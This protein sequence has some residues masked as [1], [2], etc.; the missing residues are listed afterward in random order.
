[1]IIREIPEQECRE[2][3]AR[4]SIGRLGCAFENQPYVVPI[5]FAYEPD[6][7]YA[8]STFGQKIEWMRGNPKVCL[9]VDEI[10]DQS[11]WVSIVVNGTYEELPE[12]QRPAER[13]HARELLEAKQSWWLNPIAE[14]REKVNEVLIRPV[15]F[16]IHAESMSG[17]RAIPAA[18]ERG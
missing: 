14:R 8:F 3:L 7:L 13:A 4:S 9:Q 5:L 12:L 17:L 1:M 10:A 16:R 15:F 2:L 18:D 11:H 6:Y